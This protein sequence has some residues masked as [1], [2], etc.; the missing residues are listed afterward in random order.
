LPRQ[1]R[2]RRRGLT[3]WRCLAYQTSQVVASRG[4]FDGARLGCHGAAWPTTL[5][6]SFNHTAAPQHGV[7]QAE[8]YK[9]TIL[10]SCHHVMAHMFG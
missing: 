3:W 1:C 5:A 6:R 4:V 7:V 8:W 10:S 2:R 9:F